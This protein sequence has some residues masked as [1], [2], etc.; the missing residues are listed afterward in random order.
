MFLPLKVSLISSRSYISV[1]FTSDV[2]FD[3]EA[4]ELV[5]K[6]RNIE[7]LYRS[8]IGLEKST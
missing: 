6:R 7:A 3:A 1:V 2:M 5:S 8:L 4:S